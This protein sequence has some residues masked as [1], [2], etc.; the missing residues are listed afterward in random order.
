[1]R[2]AIACLFKSSALLVM[3]NSRHLSSVSDRERASLTLAM[4]ALSYI[5]NTDEPLK[6]F[7]V[8]E[9]AERV[10]ESE[11]TASGKVLRF[12]PFYLCMQVP[13]EYVN[14]VNASCTHTHT[15]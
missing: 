14:H 2:A 11:I 1:M 5:E 13:G 15:N 9:S 4:R 10:T 8:G 3:L 6:E 7:K 12:T